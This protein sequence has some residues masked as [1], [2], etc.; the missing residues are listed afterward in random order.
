LGV[1]IRVC[2]IS[3]ALA[4]L[5]CERPSVHFRA[6]ANRLPQ[7]VFVIEE[8]RGRRLHFDGYDVRDAEGRA[9][10]TTRR[11]NGYNF[12]YR[13]LVD[14]TSREVTYGR[15]EYDYIVDETMRWLKSGGH[16]VFSTRSQFVD[17]LSTE[18]DALFWFSVD[19]RGV[20]VP[21]VQ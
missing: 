15:F 4:S 12:Q 16:Y 6:D 19:S 9:M 8:V 7:P 2:C 13:E 3:I 20:L 14:A 11:K 10:L 1:V 18:N 21:D 17:Q 5:A